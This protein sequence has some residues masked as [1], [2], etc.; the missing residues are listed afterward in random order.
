MTMKM[1]LLL[2]GGLLGVGAVYYLVT[3]K[4]A[5]A[6]PKAVAAAAPKKRL[7]AVKPAQALRFVL[8]SCPVGQ[9]INSITGQCQAV[10]R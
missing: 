5:A 3:K 2:G 9:A 10:V 4:A 8:P 1:W 6:A 7:V